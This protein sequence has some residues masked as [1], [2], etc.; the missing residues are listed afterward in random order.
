MSESEIT[1]W[2]EQYREIKS[3]L[4]EIAISGSTEAPVGTG[5][6]TL[7][8]KLNRLI[9]NVLPMQ[10]LK[11]KCSYQGV[12]KQCSNCYGYHRLE[13]KNLSKQFSCEKTTFEE[14]KEKFKADNSGIPLTMLG[15][16]SEASQDDS[17]EGYDNS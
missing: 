11:I 17:T 10:G 16:A 13:G 5:S 2:I 9:P 7:K 4:E 3:D 15:I 8:V 1:G 6:Y 12:K 14:Y